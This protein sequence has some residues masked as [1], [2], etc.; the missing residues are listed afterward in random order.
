MSAMILM[1]AVPID[2]VTP[3]AA[4]NASATET[5]R[6]LSTNTRVSWIPDHTTGGRIIR[7]DTLEIGRGVLPQGSSSISGVV[8]AENTSNV[9]RN[10]A[11]HTELVSNSLADSWMIFISSLLQYR[12]STSLSHDSAAELFCL[13]LAQPL[14]AFLSQ[15]FTL[16]VSLMFALV[17]HLL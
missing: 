8:G 2:V 10:E 1:V 4:T 3:L 13:G 14:V 6:S 7:G 5:L 11:M 12:V 16:Q 9:C 17:E 15:L